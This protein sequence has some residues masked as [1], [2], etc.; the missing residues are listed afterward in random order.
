[1]RRG[2]ARGAPRRGTLRERALT[3]P[4]RALPAGAAKLGSGRNE[5]A[6]RVG[7]AKAADDRQKAVLRMAKLKVARA[8]GL[9]PPPVPRGPRSKSAPKRM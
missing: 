5:R 2:T 4:P 1:M 9:I 3:P 8:S 6:E 7:E